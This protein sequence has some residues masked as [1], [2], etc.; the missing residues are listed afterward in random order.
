LRNQKS[1]SPRNFLWTL[2]SFLLLVLHCDLDC[3]KDSESVDQRSQVGRLWGVLQKDQVVVKSWKPCFCWLLKWKHT[4]S[5]RSWSHIKFVP[6]CNGSSFQLLYLNL[7]HLRPASFTSRNNTY[8]F[9]FLIAE[10]IESLE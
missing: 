1:Y 6:C 5:F 4:I 9:R 2:F 8:S 10:S 3:K 7:G